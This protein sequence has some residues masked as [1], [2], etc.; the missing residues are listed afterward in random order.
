MPARFLHVCWGVRWRENS[1]FHFISNKRLLSKQPSSQINKELDHIDPR[2]TKTRFHWGKVEMNSEHISI[3]FLKLY[4]PITN[5]H[6]FNTMLVHRSKIW[7]NTGMLKQNVSWNTGHG[8]HM[9]VH[10]KHNFLL[11]YFLEIQSL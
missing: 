2:H 9:Y 10:L 11:V 5:I 4:L 3:Y 8:I 6:Q 7:R 1:C